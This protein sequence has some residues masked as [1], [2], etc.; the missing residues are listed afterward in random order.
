[1]SVAQWSLSQGACL[2]SVNLA[3]MVVRVGPGWAPS[4]LLAAE[5]K[6]LISIRAAETPIKLDAR[7]A[8]LVRLR[9]AVHSQCPKT[10]IRQNFDVRRSISE[11]QT[12]AM[13]DDE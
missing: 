9:H 3:S 8:R 13:P 2:L 5:E 11:G 4:S 12:E 6:S 1:M 7:E 10:V